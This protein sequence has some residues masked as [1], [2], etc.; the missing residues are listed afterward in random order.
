[1]TQIYFLF[2]YTEK[3][4]TSLHRDVLQQEVGWVQHK[5]SH[6]K[7]QLAFE[8]PGRSCKMLWALPPSTH[9]HTH[10]PIHSHTRSCCFVTSRAHTHTVTT[11]AISPVIFH[12]NFDLVISQSC[13]TSQ[14]A[15]KQLT[16]H[17]QQFSQLNNLLPIKE[18]NKY[19]IVQFCFRVSC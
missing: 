11:V 7:L 19:H 18:T 10:T 14:K 3:V 13:A 2:V 6:F 17:Q 9:T 15:S 1:M 5:V 4:V 12:L 8:G 16:E